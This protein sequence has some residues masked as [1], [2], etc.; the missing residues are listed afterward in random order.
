MPSQG[1]QGTF[2]NLGDG[3]FSSGMFFIVICMDVA[4][5]T[6]GLLATSLD[7]QA[8]ASFCPQFLQFH[9]LNSVAAR[10]GFALRTISGSARRKK[11]RAELC[12][13]AL[14]APYQ[15]FTQHTLR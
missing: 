6:L 2:G 3:I 9:A 15:A 10:R 8:V 12:H 5:Q 11:E 13:A 1:V 4:R 7:T 14:R